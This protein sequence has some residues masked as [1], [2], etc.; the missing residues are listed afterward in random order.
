M[1]LFEGNSGVLT[2]ELL[3]IVLILY[4]G[5]TRWLVCDHVTLSYLH[6]V[7]YTHTT[8][9]TQDT[10]VKHTAVRLVAFSFPLLSAFSCRPM[11]YLLIDLT[12]SP[13]PPLTGSW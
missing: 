7:L 13:L 12:A 3:V 9:E 4:G 1:I 2:D 11:K 6:D 10:T 5:E 8:A